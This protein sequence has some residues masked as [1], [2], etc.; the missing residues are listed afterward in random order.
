M[1]YPKGVDDEDYCVYQFTAETVNY[2]YGLSNVTLSIDEFSDK[3]LS[4]GSQTN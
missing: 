2:Y 4:D 1:Y 3:A